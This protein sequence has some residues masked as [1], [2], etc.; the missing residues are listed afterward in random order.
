MNIVNFVHGY[1]EQ[2]ICE[3]GIISHYIPELF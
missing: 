1:Q 2:A 3:V